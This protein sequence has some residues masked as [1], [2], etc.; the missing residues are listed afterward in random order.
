[1]QLA[2]SLTAVFQ[3]SFLEPSRRPAVPRHGGVLI[4]MIGGKARVVLKKILS[5]QVFSTQA[6]CQTNSLEPVVEGNW[7]P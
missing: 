1:M 6:I 5:F 3:T 4:F 2:A 7:Y